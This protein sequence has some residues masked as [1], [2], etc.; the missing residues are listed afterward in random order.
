MQEISLSNVVNFVHNTVALIWKMHALATWHISLYI[1][2][3]V[4]VDMLKGKPLI[5]HTREYLANYTDLVECI[6]L[7]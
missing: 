6:M 1:A 3:N 7:A 2:N 4:Y 5:Q